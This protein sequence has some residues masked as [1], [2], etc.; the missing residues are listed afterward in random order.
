[1]ILGTNMN[2]NMLLAITNG[3][4]LDILDDQNQVVI[5]NVHLNY[6]KANKINKY[7]P[8]KGVIQPKFQLV[9]YVKAVAKTL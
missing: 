2:M 7:G 8:K 6:L 9:A 1:M 5:I 4:Q 3:Y